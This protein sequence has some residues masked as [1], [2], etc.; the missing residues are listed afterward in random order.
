[1][2]FN[3]RPFY[4]FSKKMAAKLDK[5]KKQESK[6]TLMKLILDNK[7]ELFEKHGSLTGSNTQE[8]IKQKWEEIRDEAISKGCDDLTGKSADDVRYKV[9]SK[10]KTTTLQK[11]DKM[12]GTGAGGKK[13][14]EVRTLYF[15][16]RWGRKRRV[17]SYRFL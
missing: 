11:Y 2:L 1:M 10:F 6:A 5:Q 7:D 13:L 3:H 17:T 14:S 16:L 15:M 4:D 12:K 9:Y 8:K